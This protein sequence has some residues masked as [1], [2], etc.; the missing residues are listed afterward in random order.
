MSDPNL[1]NVFALHAPDLDGQPQEVKDKFAELF[2]MA[3]QYDVPMFFLDGM[4]GGLIGYYFANEETPVPVYDYNKCIQ[5]L[6]DGF[7]KSDYESEDPDEYGMSPE[8]RMYQ[9]AVEFFSYNTDRALPY[10]HEYAPMVINNPNPTLNLD[11]PHTKRGKVRTW[12][13]KLLVK[14][15]ARL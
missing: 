6:I 14:L 4:E 11:R 1:E 7:D 15:I 8:D 9:D 3:D 2:M 10:Q 12:L 13:L 5:C